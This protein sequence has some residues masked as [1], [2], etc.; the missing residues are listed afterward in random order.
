V[1]VVKTVLEKLGL[2][3]QDVGDMGGVEIYKKYGLDI[4][5]YKEL[6]FDK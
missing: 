1:E 4:H 6:K 3:G 2:Q 5:S